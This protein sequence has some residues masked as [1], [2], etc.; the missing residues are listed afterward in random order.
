MNHALS[1]SSFRFGMAGISAL[2]IAFLL[3]FLM[4]T[5]IEN[6]NRADY[7]K[8]DPTFNIEFI[9]IPTPS[10]EPVA[11]EQPPVR[12]LDPPPDPIIDNSNRIIE[13]RLPTGFQALF[14]IPGSGNPKPVRPKI[15]SGLLPIVEVQPIYPHNAISRDIE[16][17]VVVEFT[18]TAS[19]TTDD[20]KI[21]EALPASIFN[22]AAVKATQ[23][24]RYK[25]QIVNGKPE[26]VSGMRK[27]F[28]FTLED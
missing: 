1:L 6:K 25:P 21:V 13:E 17:Y 5:L 27:M 3:F 28:T 24:S 14:K 22:K 11:E 19:G 10:V 4:H 12:P 8:P 7:V 15:N 26:A 9:V 20:I 23:K 16:G 2:F 18:V